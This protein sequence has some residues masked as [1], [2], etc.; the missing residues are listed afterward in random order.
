MKKLFIDISPGFYKTKLLTEISKE[1]EV[2]AVYTTD[3]DKSTRNADF[4]QGERPY[5]YIDLRG[6]RLQQ[7][8]R[9]LKTVLFGG[10]DEVIVGG[11]DS[12]TAWLPVLVSPKKRNS[13]IIE[14]TFRDTKPGGL[15]TLLKKLFFK[16]ISRAYVCGT[17]HEKLTRMFGF[18]GV[19]VIWKSVGLINRVQQ[20]PYTERSLV[21]NFLFVGRLIEEKN[22]E[23]LI[24]RFA[25]HPKLHLSI[26]GFGP[27]EAELKQCVT[28][29]NINFVGAVNNKE[30]SEWYQK[31]D[32][33]ILPS[34]S[35][36]WGL[37]IEEALNNGTPVM[38][39]DAV[40]C[41]DDLVLGQNTGV[42]FKS[43]DQSD[44]DAKIRKITDAK[45]Y[46]S[47]RRTIASMDFEQRE[48]SI[49]KAFVHPNHANH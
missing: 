28:T 34:K 22:L 24:D 21:K 7:W 1:V 10:F 46:N 43:F 17:P 36:T 37:V 6:N 13:A 31:S 18:K 27:L 48:H 15:K 9:V 39:S 47:F 12:V 35:E 33:F 45:I 4:L 26:V 32:V 19:C 49:V 20:P 8:L 16:R 2:F 3:Y 23:W 41:A 5:G 38:V 29:E 44:F 14:S 11:Y 25:A 30:L 40:G 42:V